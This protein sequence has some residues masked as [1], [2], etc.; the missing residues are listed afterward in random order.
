MTEQSESTED[1]MGGIL[2]GGPRNACIPLAR[3]QPHDLI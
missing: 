2:E 1:G 3:T